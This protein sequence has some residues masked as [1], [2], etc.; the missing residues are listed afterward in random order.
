MVQ[1]ELPDY[2]KSLG[3]IGVAPI[4]GYPGVKALG[5]T[6]KECLL[7][8]ELHA[9]AALFN[10][11]RFR[12][13]VVL[14]L[15]DL[16]IEAEALGAKVAFEGVEAPSICSKT[17]LEDA[18]D[19]P[20]VE[21]P[22]ERLMT[23]AAGK[24]FQ[25]TRGLPGG[26]F[27]TGPFTMAGQVVG[28]E[29]LLRGALKGQPELLRLLDHCTEVVTTY[30][31][32]LEGAGADFLVIAD[33]SSSLISAALFQRLCKSSISKV[34]SCVSVG[35][36]LHICGRSGHL[37]RHMAETGVAGISL[38]ENVKLADA[39][40]SIPDSL[41]VF[42]NYSPTDLIS[43]TPAEVAFNVRAML[44][45]AKGHSN[46]VASTGCDIPPA[47]PI[48][49]IEAFVKAAKSFGA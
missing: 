48:E 4:I 17:L 43:E 45:Q 15:L 3:R 2:F 37:L 39:L 40:V 5:L 13:D 49:N 41:L 24:I 7:N 29:T 14:P 34:R 9:K 44:D 27:V 23:R 10:V 18:A 26:F 22:R 6:S 38:D 28:I 31:K 8:P 36:V 21:P 47:S 19:A 35:V 25:R 11:N 33:P 20:A 1:L 12:P 16:T 32:A 30:A 42:G 46:F